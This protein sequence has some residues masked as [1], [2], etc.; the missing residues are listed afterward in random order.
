[1]DNSQIKFRMIEHN[2]ED[3]LKCLE[4]RQEITKREVDRVNIKLEKYY[5]HLVAKKGVGIIAI[6]TL[7]P[8]EKNCQIKYMYF[9]TLARNYPFIQEQMLKLCQR[10]GWFYGFDEM[11]F[12]RDGCKILLNLEQNLL[13]ERSS[14]Q[15][16]NNYQ[17]RLKNIMIYLIKNKDSLLEYEIDYFLANYHQF[18]GAV[19]DE[20]TRGMITLQCKS[21]I[22]LR[23]NTG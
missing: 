16:Y 20:F 18:F 23:M 12:E 11:F 15:N 19:K 4:L 6:A 22:N 17:D 5:I 1:M 8:I 3:Y 13:G 7:K 9:S 14:D 2:S 10:I 21:N